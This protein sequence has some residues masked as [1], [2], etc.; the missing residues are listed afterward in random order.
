MNRNPNIF[1]LNFVK[2]K[3]T[4]L[5]CGL[6][7]VRCVHT[8]LLLLSPNNS[9]SHRLFFSH[10]NGLI[11]S[12]ILNSYLLPQRYHLPFPCSK[13]T[14]KANYRIVRLYSACCALFFLNSTTDFSNNNHKR[15]KLIEAI[16]E[17]TTRAYSSKTRLND[18]QRLLPSNAHCIWYRCA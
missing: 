6:H 4:Y 14:R 3:I 8:E 11:L 7:L 18:R 2:F 13:H 17:G 5:R 12:L 10:L 16:D 15:I 9:H 1:Q